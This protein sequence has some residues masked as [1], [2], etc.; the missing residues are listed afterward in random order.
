VFDFDTKA[1]TLGRILTYEYF[2]Y[3]KDFFQQYQKALAAVTRADV[4]RVAKE[5]LDPQRFTL[6]TVG[7]PKDF[8]QGLE[9]L[10]KP[11]TT[12][13]LTIAG[14]TPERA[15]RAVRNGG[16]GEAVLN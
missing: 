5:H 15:P 10:G 12:I 11:V 14:E 9:T 1:K 2:S 13:D 8:G 7:N 3:P 16:R 4:L 6:V